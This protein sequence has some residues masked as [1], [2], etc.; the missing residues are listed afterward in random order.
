MLNEYVDL[1]SKKRIVKRIS[2]EKIGRRA[3]FFKHPMWI[4]STTKVPLLLVFL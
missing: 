4:D 3:L 2:P 1:T